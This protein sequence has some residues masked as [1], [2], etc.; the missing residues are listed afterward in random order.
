MRAR[1]SLE[2]RKP[3]RDVRS[4]ILVVCEG[5]I[6]EPEYLRAFIR[7]TRNNLAEVEIVG[8]AGDPKR[9]VEHALERRR[10][11]D[12]RAQKE[13]DSTLKFDFVWCVFDVDDHPRLNDARQQARD[14]GIR[15]AVSNPCI[16]LWLLIHF[17][18]Y[19]RAIDRKS[20]SSRL[21]KHLK[22][23]DKHINAE[24]LLGSYSQAVERSKQL[25][26]DRQS[27]STLGENPSTDFDLLTELIKASGMS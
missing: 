12:A 7:L 27:S 17:I 10:A 18:E 2:R 25:R 13:S 9:I 24:A 20:L 6:T 11:A 8:G 21:K 19:R 22:G 4:R 16:E 5:K 15:L 26:R 23:Y 1:A 14:N 3:T